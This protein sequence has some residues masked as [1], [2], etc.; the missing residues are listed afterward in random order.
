MHDVLMPVADV[1]IPDVSI[2]ILIPHVFVLLLPV[3]QQN[4]H[5]V[6]DASD[7]IGDLYNTAQGGV[8]IP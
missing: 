5:L 6:N 4:L 2:F 3:Y 7:A 8:L 1:A